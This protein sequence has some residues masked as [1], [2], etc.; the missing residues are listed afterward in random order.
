MRKENYVD[1]LQYELKN[2]EFDA[3][4]Q[5]VSSEIYAQARSWNSYSDSSERMMNRICHH[6]NPDLAPDYSPLFEQFSTDSEQR[7]FVREIMFRAAKEI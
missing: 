6:L 1:G 4:G 7:Q 3:N 2:A 5:M